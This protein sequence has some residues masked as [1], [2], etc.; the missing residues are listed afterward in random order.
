M[1]KIIAEIGWNHMGNMDL[2]KKMIKSASNSGA[3]YCKFQTWSVKNLTSGP[4]DDDG[5]REI[6]EKAELSKDQ[7]ILLR[8][9]C[10][11]N[12]TKFMTSVFNI[13][14]IKFLKELDN[15]IIKIPSHEVYNLELID[16]ACQNF[17]QVLISTGA[18]KWE[19]IKKI[20]NQFHKYKPVLMHCVSSYPCDLSKINFP[21]LD[22]LKELSKE[23]GYSGHFPGI[24]DALVAITKD[25]KYVEKHFTVDKKLPGR[26]NEFAILPEELRLK[27]D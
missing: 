26:D 23:V 17:D 15:S 22:K 5:R 10:L 3:D 7:H 11:E 8:N 6:Y 9:F 1:I 2:A 12:N 20:N 21:R 18:S 4:W 19:E 14:D 27:T 16:Q 25:L 13:E 24:D